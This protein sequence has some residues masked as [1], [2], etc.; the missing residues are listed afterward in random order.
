M[1]IIRTEGDKPVKIKGYTAHHLFDIMENGEQKRV[2]VHMKKPW[3]YRNFWWMSIIIFAGIAA[4][5]V[6]IG[7]F[8]F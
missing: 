1:K 7:D 2:W 5:K 6:W 4:Y 8:A 3:W